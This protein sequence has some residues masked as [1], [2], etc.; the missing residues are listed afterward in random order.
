L[1]KI[2]LTNKQSESENLNEKETMMSHLTRINE[3]KDLF[4]EVGDE[5]DNL[6]MINEH[7]IKM[8]NDEIER[9]KEDIQE[10]E[11]KI[12]NYERVL[13]FYKEQYERLT[14]ENEILGSRQS[15][16]REDHPVTNSQNKSLV[17]YDSNSSSN[18]KSYS[19]IKKS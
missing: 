17:N 16:V 5:K 13:L 7:G 19:S 11:Q 10:K 8:R 3:R 6:L 15:E 1:D 9:L 14:K 2:A 18:E 4:C 12:T